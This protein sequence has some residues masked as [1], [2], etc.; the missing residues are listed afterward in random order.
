MGL[1]TTKSCFKKDK[2]FKP[3]K[4]AKGFLGVALGTMLI[5][6]ASELLNK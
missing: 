3:L 2:D 5:G 1:K 6:K 4:M